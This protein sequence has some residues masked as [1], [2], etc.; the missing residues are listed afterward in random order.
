MHDA[1]QLQELAADEGAYFHMAFYP[2]ASQEMLQSSLVLGP[3]EHACIA[4][5]RVHMSTKLQFLATLCI[6]P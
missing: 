4:G 5:L 6:S 1:V 2:V 3:L